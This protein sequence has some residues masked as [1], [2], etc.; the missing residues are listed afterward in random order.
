MTSGFAIPTHPLPHP[1]T[2]ADVSPFK[3]RQCSASQCLRVRPVC[4]MY[5]LAHLLQV[6][7]YTTPF[8]WF[9]GTG[10]L[11]CTS[12]WQTMLSGQKATLMSGCVRILLTASERPLMYG[13]VTVVLGLLTSTSCLCT[14]VLLGLPLI[15]VHGQACSDELNGRWKVN[16]IGD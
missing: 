14:H 10:S 6:M 16:N 7:E 13:R 5:T 11:G 2:R 1:S 9:S 15:S 4:S 3:A 12:M 8:C